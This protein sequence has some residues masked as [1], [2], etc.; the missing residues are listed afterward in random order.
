MITDPPDFFA[1]VPR[2]RLRDPPHRD[3]VCPTLESP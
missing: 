1:A 3:R 2:A